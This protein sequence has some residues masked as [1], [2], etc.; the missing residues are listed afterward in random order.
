MSASGVM[1]PGDSLQVHGSYSVFIHA[2][3][4]AATLYNSHF[5]TIPTSFVPVVKL[6]AVT[7]AV[8]I[9]IDLAGTV[10]FQ[11]TDPSARCSMVPVNIGG[12]R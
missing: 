8:G 1:C 4:A 10:V 9:F 2:P 11:S 6:D 12:T 5:P 3:A 7:P